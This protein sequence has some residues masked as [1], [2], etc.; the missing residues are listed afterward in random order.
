[1]HDRGLRHSGI[2]PP[3]HPISWVKATGVSTTAS[4]RRLQNTEQ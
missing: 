4:K 2:N 3:I 1:M